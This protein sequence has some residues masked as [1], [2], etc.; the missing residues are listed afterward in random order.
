MRRWSVLVAL[1]VMLLP[2][3]LAAQ[4]VPPVQTPETAPVPALD[5]ETLQLLIQART[6]LE[7]LANDQLGTQR[8]T[9]WSGSMDVYN[10]QLPLLVRLDL[11]LLVG[12][13]IAPDQRPPGWFGPIPGTPNAIARDIRHDLELLADTVGQPG[14][15]PTGWVGGD[16]L[17]RCDRALQTLVSLLERSGFLLAV[18]TNSPDFCRL[19]EQQTTQFA[20]ANNIVANTAPGVTTAPTATTGQAAPVAPPGS[21]R[22]TGDL[23]LGF[24]NRYATEHV[25]L[26]PVG[27]PLTPVARSFTEFSRMMLVRGDGFE[28][29]VDHRDTTVTEAEFAVLPDVN[30][31]PVNTSC[32]A[33]WCQPVTYTLGSPAARRSLPPGA[34]FV[35]RGTQAVN[36]PGGRVKVPVEHL[37]IYYDGQD[38]NN[39]TVVRMQ[40]C[41]KP[42]NQPGNTCQ[43]VTS[44]TAPNGAPLVSVGNVSGI[45]QFRLPYGYSTHA[46]YAANYYM[47][48]VWIAA[49]GQKR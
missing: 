33:G 32:D 17:L 39:S 20:Q 1:V 2:A 27:T 35:G 48:D 45:P 28:L 41:A 14:I 10:A 47:T 9:G 38:A 49:L 13:L 34:A 44:V 19:A 23:A 5:N 36:N 16:P 8:P 7:L 31:V 30:G 46:L 42:T 29:F 18:D 11:E 43:N 25:G 21:A 37:I 12:T 6:D 3:V 26:M 4:D 24:L 15:R 22:I 40:L